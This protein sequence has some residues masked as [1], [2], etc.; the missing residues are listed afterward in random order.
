[1]L[2]C[3]KANPL[4][5]QT[6]LHCAIQFLNLT[7]LVGFSR[8]HLPPLHDYG[9]SLW[10]NQK[11]NFDEYVCQNVVSSERV[12][13]LKHVEPIN[14]HLERGII[15]NNLW[16]K[17]HQQKRDKTHF[18]ATRFASTEHSRCHTARA[19]GEQDSVTK[20]FFSEGTILESSLQQTSA[21]AN[22]AINRAP[23]NFNSGCNAADTSS[24][25][26]DDG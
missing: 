8:T 11:L 5:A 12:E 2:L 20:P 19:A 16:Q 1:M 23:S 17:G 18:S 24:A 7:I 25:M 9:K 14:K 26:E 15:A 22:E 13:A 6:V 21:A 3:L 10:L 4:S